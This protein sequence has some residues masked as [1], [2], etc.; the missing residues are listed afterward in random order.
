[1]AKA[2]KPPKVITMQ[3]PKTAEDRIKFLT[4]DR[5]RL[6]HEVERLFALS[7]SRLK[8]YVDE[9]RKIRDLNDRIKDLV[10]EIRMHEG[11]KELLRDI[12]VQAM[13]AD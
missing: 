8:S 12:I 13:R 9:E 5:D 4:E 7:Q 3:L 1:M 11:E 10:E 2:G 6:K